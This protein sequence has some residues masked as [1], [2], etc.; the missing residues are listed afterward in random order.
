MKTDKFYDYYSIFGLSRTMS[1]SEIKKQMRVYME[2]NRKQR[3]GVN[4]NNKEIIERLD[5]DQEI[6]RNALMALC[7]DEARKKY[8]KQLDS[9]PDTSIIVKIDTNLNILDQEDELPSADMN[10]SVVNDISSDSEK[11][12]Y[13]DKQKQSNQNELESI[14]Q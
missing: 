9:M 10:N 3:V 13:V 8:D 1:T 2:E 14:I 12:N 11:S 6:I 5:A 7:Y 4:R